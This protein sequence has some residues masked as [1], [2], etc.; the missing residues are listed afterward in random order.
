MRFRCLIS[1]HAI[2][3][4]NCET[5]WFNGRKSESVFA[6]R[7]EWTDDRSPRFLGLDSQMMWKSHYKESHYF[8][9]LLTDFVCFSFVLFIF[10]I[11]NVIEANWLRVHRWIR[12]R[13]AYNDFSLSIH[14]LP[15]IIDF[16][17]AVRAS[18]SLLFVLKQFKS[19]KTKSLQ[20]YETK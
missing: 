1:K 13:A 17:T 5:V 18:L 12:I 3:L 9:K 7:Y 10:R 2:S 15:L 4:S 14:H 8:S 20:Q 11:S 6:L 16:R 19:S